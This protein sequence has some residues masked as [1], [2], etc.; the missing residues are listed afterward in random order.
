MSPALTPAAARPARRWL[1][2]PLLAPLN[3]PR[4]WDRVLA[5]VNPNWSLVEARARVST[6]I[7]EAPGVTSLWL[8]PNRNF[9]GF[10]AGQH[11]L[12]E[13]EI[14]GARHA[15]CFS[16]SHAPRADGQLRLTIKRKDGGLVSSA[17][18][19]LQPGQIVR[20]S[21]AQGDFGPSKTETKLMLLSAGSGI[22]P[23][24]SILH[25]LAASDRQRDV[26]LLH[27]CRDAS[28]L[29][30]AAELR[31]LA[32]NW[33]QLTVHLHQ[34]GTL[35]HLNAR[36][37]VELLPDWASREAL[38]C[39][40]DGYADMVHALYAAS[41]RSAQLQRESFGRR[42]TPIDP[43]AQ[44]HTITAQ[45]SEQVFTTSAGQNLLEAAE[46]A[47]LKPRFGCRRGI[48]RSCQCRKLSGSVT[49]LLTG[50]SSGGGEELIQ[51]CISSPL[52]AV[53]LAL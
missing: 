52:N 13:L 21:Q 33:P 20:I 51:L 50:L 12:L 7:V 41:G 8:Q 15:R 17:A 11:V 24:L 6:V 53:E 47:G 25:D 30:A 10:R 49:N 44:N 39:G 27:T 45:R 26:V 40:P 19:R 5:L 28:D 3:D 4:S 22:T 35:G 2:H 14:D 32:S 36:R 48:C 43:N 38:L 9:R 16:L 23:M 37:I 34:S 18:Q 29:I 42:P 46:A 31:A 1:R